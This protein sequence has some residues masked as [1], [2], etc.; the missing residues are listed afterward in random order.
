MFLTGFD[1]KRLN[2]LYVD[3]KLKFHS[4]IQA[5]SRTN[6]I[7]KRTKPHGNI[8]CYQT[9]KK[10]VDDAIKIFSQT[11]NTDIVLM[12]SYDEYLEQFNNAL[13][14]LKKIASNVENVDKLEK[15]EDKKVFLLAFRD[16]S[17]VLVS[18]QTF[19][20]FEFDESSVGI[21]NQ[22]YQDYKSK[23]LRIVRELDNDKEKV[24]ILSDIDFSLELMQTDKINVSYII[25][26]IRN[27]DLNDKEQQYKDIIDI[28]QKLVNVTDEELYLKIDLIKR[29]LQNVVP[30][31][32][33]D[34][35]IDEAYNNHLNKER[36]IEIEKFAEKYNI[37][38][39]NMKEII[40][41]YEYSGIFPDA[42]IKTSLSGNFLEK[43]KTIQ[44]LKLFIH[45]IIKKYL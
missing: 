34:D 27:I 16:L 5:F 43:R 3:K 19:N 30:V 15:E 31:L 32:Q 6:R 29:F 7:E 23:Y 25:N 42:K 37:S 41:E 45:K 20:E 10:D 39:E 24:S 4:L 13:S 40:D 17:R 28:E 12:K 33:N 2:T 44:D 11:E 22:E 38:T 36:I 14:E 18:L 1:S 9:T 35:S 21:S 26:L 8:V